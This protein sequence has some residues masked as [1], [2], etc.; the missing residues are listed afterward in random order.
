MTKFK[1]PNNW[2]QR[3][4]NFLDSKFTGPFGI[5]FGYDGLI[6][7]IP[8]IGDIVTTFLGLFIVG[9]AVTLGASP[10][11]IIRMLIN[12]L[13]DNLLAKIPIIGFGIDFF[14]RA[15]QK[16]I[17]LLTDYESRPSQVRP[18]SSLYILFWFLIMS[19]I[20]LTF[21]TLTIYLL[22]YLIH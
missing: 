8:G 11:I 4:A 15:N 3:L 17:A 2:P 1:I 14:W 19:F 9:H 12:L 21:F 18:G 13:I 16:N 22:I 7:L 20:M 6:G 10:S 5:Q